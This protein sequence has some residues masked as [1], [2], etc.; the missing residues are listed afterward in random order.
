MRVLIA[1]DNKDAAET[2]AMLVEAWGYETITVYDGLA[3]LAVL[4][5]TGAPTL[6]LL[7]WIMPGMTG[8]DICREI[9]KDKARPYTYVILVTGRGDKDQMLAGLK[10]GADDYLIKPVEA[11]EMQARLHTGKR[12][13]ELQEQLLAT[14]RQ[15]REQ[16]TRDSLT[17]LWNRA[18]ILEI[19]DRELARSRREGKLVSVIM[20][21]LDHFKSINDT[22]GHLVGDQVLR[23]TAERLRGVLRPYDT[24][25]R[26]GGEEFLI[27]LP[28]CS[29]ESALV[30]ADRLRRCI[31]AE[32]FRGQE[33]TLPLTLSLGI[34]TGDGTAPPQELLRLA[35][36]ALYRAKREGR[37]RA[38]TLSGV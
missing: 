37:N 32:L 6:V 10:A 13:V 38:A 28:G 3:A 1:D 30:L 19:F 25:G 14:Q 9:R 23:Q 15:L 12:I 26:Y 5:G 35:D 21:D 27:V 34:A 22:H 29:T 4:Q 17:G 36:S 8:I 33:V 11:N 20:A 18:T 7:D 2:L 16:A 31:E 24:V